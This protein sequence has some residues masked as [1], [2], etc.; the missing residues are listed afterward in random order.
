[1][2]Q[3]TLKVLIVDDAPIVRERFSRILSESLPLEIVGQAQTI[4]QALTILP[5]TQPDVVL[6]DLRLPDGSGLHVLQQIRETSISCKVIMMT[7]T[8]YPYYRERCLAAGADYFFDKSE[9]FEQVI[10]LLRHG[11]PRQTQVAA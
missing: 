8:P 10:E 3:S 7:T 2:K 5:T 6:L 4:K 9:E 11:L 1:M